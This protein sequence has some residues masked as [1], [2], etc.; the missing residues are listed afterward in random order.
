[1]IV[2]RRRREDVTPNV[3]VPGVRGR[4]GAALRQDRFRFHER[5]GPSRS[6]EP[7]STLPAY[8]CRFCGTTLADIIA[9]GKPGCCSCY[10]TVRRRD[11]TGDPDRAGLH[12]PHRQGSRQMMFR[13]DSG[14]EWIRGEGPDSDIVISTRARL[15]RSLAA[16]PF[17]SRSSGEDLSMVVRDV[18]AACGGL[19]ARF[20][21]LSMI[22]MD[23]LDAGAEERCCWTLMWSALSRP[24]TGPARR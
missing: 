16:Y 14:P 12:S 15:A 11:R 22:S 5:A 6:Q 3:C 23:K 20:P 10:A 2:L 19:A 17:P 13:P 1:M 24:K 9:D 4:A 18:R 7:P 8:S 21:G